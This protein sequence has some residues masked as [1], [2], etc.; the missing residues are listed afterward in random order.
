MKS[1][2]FTQ[3][4]ILL[5]WRNVQA[6]KVHHS[7]IEQGYGVADLTFYTASGDVEIENLPLDL[8]HA[9]QDYVLAKVEEPGLMATLAPESPDS[10]DVM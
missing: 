8:V 2:F 5:L 1:G 7:F 4:Q 6:L 9:L 3:S 10:I